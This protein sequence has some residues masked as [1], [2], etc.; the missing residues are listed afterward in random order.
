MRIP[1]N[2]CPRTLGRYTARII[3][4]PRRMPFSQTSATAWSTRLAGAAASHGW[5]MTASETSSRLVSIT[6]ALSAR[7]S[8]PT[9]LRPE[10]LRAPHRQRA[11]RS[12]SR[13]RGRCCTRVAWHSGQ[14][15]WDT[16][17]SPAQAPRTHQREGCQII[18][19][20][21]RFRLCFVLCAKSLEEDERSWQR[22][23]AEIDLLTKEQSHDHSS[24]T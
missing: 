12:C 10:R 5:R 3:V 6:F 14:I 21:L 7:D 15:P 11:E 2:H 17:P 23:I 20:R 4:R 18:R 1:S 13:R 16:R 22:L 8:P 24:Q 19:N 9:P